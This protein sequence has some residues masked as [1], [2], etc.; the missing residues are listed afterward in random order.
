M[1]PAQIQTILA[2]AQFALGAVTAAAPLIP[3]AGP[4][5]LLASGIANAA[6]TAITNA[7]NSG[8][9]VTDAQLAAIKSGVLAAFAADTA[10][11]SGVVGAGGVKSMPPGTTAAGIPTKGV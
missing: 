3:G 4:G 9:D 2:D 7:Y 1:T 5:V 11:T 8:T 6:L 10:A